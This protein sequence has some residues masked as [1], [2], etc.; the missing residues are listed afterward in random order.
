MAM[1]RSTRV[2]DLLK[3]QDRMNR[4]LEDS[5]RGSR[6]E[7]QEEMDIIIWMSLVNNYETESAV[8]LKAELPGISQEEYR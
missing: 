1:V 3:F 7:G 2:K 6:H 4:L 5:V 8:V